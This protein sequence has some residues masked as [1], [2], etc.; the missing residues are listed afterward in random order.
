MYKLSASNQIPGTVAAVKEGAVNGVVTLDTAAGFVKADISMEAIRELGLREGADATAVINACDVLLREDEPC[1]Y[2]CSAGNAFVGEV[3]SLT[4]GAVSAI[5]CIKV[6]GDIEL[7]SNME[8]E[9]A[10]ALGL[11]PGVG[12][13]VVVSSNDVLV[14][15]EG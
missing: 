2:S 13:L 4:P 3:A 14:S 5:A 8:L 9:C 15:C 1:G 11:K 12:V 6:A 7:T 10:D